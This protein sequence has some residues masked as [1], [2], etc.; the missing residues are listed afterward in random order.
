[1]IRKIVI[2]LL[3][4]F[5]TLTPLFAQND[6][7]TPVGANTALGLFSPAMAGR[8]GFT[9]ST[10]GSAASAIN[11]A[12]EGQAQ[13]MIFDAGFLA[14]PRFGEERDFG[15][16]AF[17]LGAIF[18]T[19]YGVFG[20]SIRMLRSP[21]EAFPIETF[22]LGNLNAAKEIFPGMSVGAGIN[23]GHNSVNNFT[24]SGDLGFRYNMGNMGPLGNFT[25]ALTAKSLGTSW[26]PSAFTPAGGVSFDFLHLQGEGGGVD[27]LR[28][29][30]AADLMVPTFQNL[31]GSFGLSIQIA[32][33]INLSA[34]SRFNIR[35][36][37]R[38]QGPSPVPSIGIG[39]NWRL[40]NSGYTTVGR[41]IVPTYGEMAVDLAAMPLYNGIWAMGGG[42]TWTVGVF[43][44]NPPVITIYYP[45]PAWI[46]PNNDGRADYLEFPVTIRDE[47]YVVEWVFEI[48]DDSGDLA[49]TI[50][51]RELRPETQGVQN[52]IER[53]LAV[54]TGVE[55]PPTLR[56]DGMLET[57]A[58]APDGRYYFTISATDDNGNT[59]RIG[60]FEVNVR[61]T[62]PEITLTPFEGDMNIFAPGGGGE[63][64]TLTITQ[65]GSVEDLWEA[66]IYNI[67]GARVRTFNFINREP[68][69]IVWDGRDD[70]GS[71]VPDGVYTY[72]I[73]AT[74]RALNS[75]EAALENIIVNTIRPV[76]GLSIPH[77]F[78]S[79]TGDGVLDTLIL[80]LSVPVR[81]DIA[82]WELLIRDF[83]G[84]V[85]RTYSGTHTVPA[86]IDFDGRDNAGRLLPEAVYTASLAVR[87]RNGFVATAFSPPFTL[88][89][90]PPWAAVQIEAE[91][92]EAG[93]PPAFSP[94]G[95]RNRLVIIQE[96]SNEVSWTGEVRRQGDPAG[97]PVR[98]FRFSGT[99]PRRIEWDGITN[100]GALA[101][102]GFYTFA[103]VSTD[104]AGNTGRSNTVVFEVDTR[105]TPVFISTNIRAF[106]PGTD[107]PRSSINL[108][109]LIQERDGISTWQIEI[110]NL[111]TGASVRSFDGRDTVPQQINWDGRTAAGV[112]A[113]DGTYVARLDLEYW[114][115]HRPNS[116]SLSFVLDTIPPEGNLSVPFT[117][118]APNGNGNRD[119]LPIQ[120]MTDGN[121]EWNLT[122]TDSNNTPVRTWNWTGRTPMVPIIWDARDEA[123]NIVEDGNYNITL[124][125]TDEA[126]NSTQRVINNIVV[127]AR[128]P[129]IFLTAS[130]QAIAPRPNPSEAMRFNVLATIPDGIDF[131]RL[132]LRDENNTVIRTFPSAQG[133]SGTLPQVIPWDGA[134]ESGVVVEGLFTPTLT[135]HY[136]KG[137]IVTTSAAAVLVDISGP[138]LG[139]RHY[140]EYFSPDNDG[141]ND[142]LFIF[143]T[144]IDASPIADW[145][146]EIRETEGTRQLFWRIE[147]RG[148]P[149]ERIIWDGR[150]NW[151]ELVQGATD[152]QFIYT[153]TDAL[154]NSSTITGIISTDVLVI[155]DGDILRIQ[156]P[157]IVFRANHADF[158]GIPQDR[159]E[160]NIRVLRRVAEILNRF[161]DYRITVEGH[162]NPVLGTARE[163][164]EV[165]MPLSFARSQFVIDHLA[166]LGVS[167]ARLSPI[168]RGG[169][170]N[171][172]D[173]RDQDN[174]WKN[175]RVEFLLI[176]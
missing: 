147:G 35:E 133:G 18:P 96:G 159:L 115:G 56:W 100:E 93:R 68:E 85:Q 98:T 140:P 92:I 53:L 40:G 128:I 3:L 12:A 130:S 44:N 55:V 107:S 173:P 91:N 120:V 172:A 36:S 41:T 176:R 99:P 117:I 174:S 26:I 80:N 54:R 47:R 119:T 168:G 75:S 116:L 30:L 114:A 62:P 165:L 89:I 15:F 123:G 154:G 8:G 161:R 79:P 65:R 139:F 11:P 150:S 81:E 125:S 67:L 138:V 121:D 152:Y 86:R 20:G 108:I 102:D 118:F 109:P 59:G 38:G 31:A 69:T 46:S 28:M 141:V 32:E 4:G 164:N 134:N 57:G 167:R 37:S 131:W 66:G 106:S 1:M 171:I 129:Q 101:P 151:G 97:N 21:F 14:L 17:N 43:D 27:P 73:S 111:D 25:W 84:T 94:T 88:D 50:R 95:L 104:L 110:F 163:E 60:P 160:N 64:D 169:G 166:G 7:L 143:L 136:T 146:L 48:F 158:I 132:E 83:A 58:V 90:T 45:R 112:I 9:T 127:D 10:G 51:N 13:R 78:F 162:A 72:R 33:L 113:P 63:K 144:A 49:R 22:F 148:T 105:D 6:G 61:N 19:R 155:R 29:T 122:V 157:S 135:V 124:D 42:I 153:A 156:I 137:D 2:S 103:L 170:M 76:V 34:G 142:E 74:D 5:S 23:I 145:S 52:I 70:A 175:R 77:A 82:G 71:F 24:F 149:A 39:M 16:G 126:G 87:Y